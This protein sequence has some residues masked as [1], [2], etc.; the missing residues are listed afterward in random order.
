MDRLESLRLEIERLVGDKM[1]DKRSTGQTAYNLCLPFEDKNP[2]VLGV[3]KD[4]SVW[5]NRKDLGEEKATLLTEELEKLGI[6]LEE[7]PYPWWKR[8]DE[9]INLYNEDPIEIANRVV[10]ALFPG[11]Q[12][13]NK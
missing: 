9:K 11:L 10:A 4:G 2:I 3:Y 5:T 6:K 13:G 1:G 12:T 7:S 8:K